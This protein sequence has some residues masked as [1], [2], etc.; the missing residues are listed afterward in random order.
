MALGKLSLNLIGKLSPSPFPGSATLA[1]AGAPAGAQ[2]PTLVG[3]AHSVVGALRPVSLSLNLRRADISSQR[4]TPWKDYNT[5][6]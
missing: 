3:V 1:P 6:R 2:S 4:F 5:N